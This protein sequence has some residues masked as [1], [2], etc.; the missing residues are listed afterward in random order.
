MISV[1]LLTLVVGVQRPDPLC[2]E[3]TVE[4]NKSTN[5]GATEL[6]GF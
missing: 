4:N 5:C 2:N 1:G 3:S 6:T